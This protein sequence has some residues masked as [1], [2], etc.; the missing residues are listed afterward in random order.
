MPCRKTG[1][2]TMNRS[3]ESITRMTSYRLPHYGSSPSHSLRMTTD[4]SLI[5]TP[6]RLR[7]YDAFR[8]PLLVTCFPKIVIQNGGKNALWESRETAMWHR[9]KNLWLGWHLTV[10]LTTVIDPSLPL[11]MTP[12]VLR[13]YDTFRFPHYAADPLLLFRMTPNGNHM[14]RLLTHS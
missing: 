2:K 10:F 9:V 12:N 6:Y 5:I 7:H 14:L 3:E 1:N 11:R 8:S 4:V 13:H